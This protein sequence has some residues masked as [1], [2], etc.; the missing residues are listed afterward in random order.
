MAEYEFTAEQNEGID[1]LRQKLLHVSLLFLIMGGIQ[2][3]GSFFFAGAGARWVSLLSSVLFLIMGWL[4]M[5]PLDNFKRVTTTEGED[6]KEMMIALS[7]LRTA[8]L[9]AEIV[10]AILVVAI[11]A[12]IMRLQYPV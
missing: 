8:F 10:V 2:L 3:V 1:Q 4:F 9:L 11:I 7:D 12:E 6:I 5:R